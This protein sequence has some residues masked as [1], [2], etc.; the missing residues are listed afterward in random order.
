MQYTVKNVEEP[1]L[2]LFFYEYTFKKADAQIKGL[3]LPKD[4]KIKDLARLGNESIQ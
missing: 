4:L 3:P 1:K 2:A